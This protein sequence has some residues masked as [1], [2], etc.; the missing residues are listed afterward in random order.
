[1]TAWFSWNPHI[2]NML[3][4]HLAQSARVKVSQKVL[5]SVAISLLS[6][7]ASNTDQVHDFST[8]V[9]IKNWPNLKLCLILRFHSFSAYQNV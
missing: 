9:A 4:Q 5:S 1:M 6:S 7:P 3:L 8:S 2:G